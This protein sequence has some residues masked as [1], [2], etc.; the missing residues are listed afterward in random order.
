MIFDMSYSDFRNYV[1]NQLNNFFPDE[2]FANDEIKREFDVAVQRT[3]KC[4]KCISLPSYS[5]AYGQTYI[6][7]YHADQY[8]TFLYFLSNTIWESSK[9]KVIC[10]KIISLNR[11]LHGFFYSYKCKL[12]DIFLFGHPL[13]SVIGNACYHDF[14]VVFQNVTIN[15]SQNECG[16]LAPYIGR[17]V[18]L[19]AGAKIIGNKTIG[20]RVSIGVNTTIYNREIPDDSIAY[21]DEEG[22]LI[23]KNREKNCQAQSFFRVPIQ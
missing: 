12:P 16:E 2:Q 23:V 5:D 18:F 19:G 8:A 14:L 11:L 10:D 13:G 3:E 21:T 4:F 22:Q 20:N 17:G 15:T 6:S 1:Y 7:P 9:N